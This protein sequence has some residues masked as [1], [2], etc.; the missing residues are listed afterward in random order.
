MGPAKAIQTSLAHEN[1]AGINNQDGAWLLV[2]GKLKY[3]VQNGK[4]R[5]KEMVQTY[6]Q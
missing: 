3:F 4:L 5:L 1:S 6:L 2:N